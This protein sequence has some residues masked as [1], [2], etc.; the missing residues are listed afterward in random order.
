MVVVIVLMVTRPW[1]RRKMKNKVIATLSGGKDSMF[2]LHK[3]VK[4]GYE[5]AAIVNTISQDFK[6]VRFHGLEAQMIQMQA[7]ALGIPLFQIETTPENYKEEFIANLK[8]AMTPKIGGIVF[9]DIFLEDC[10]IWAKEVSSAVG[11]EAIEPHWGSNS[12]QLLH[13]FVAS[14]IQAVVVSTQANLLGKEWIGRTID[15]SFYEDITKLEGIDPCG[16]NGEY[17]TYVNDSPLFQKRIVL[18]KT[19][20]VERGGYHFLDIQEASLVKKD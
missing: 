9:G 6:R 8:R 7:D 13:N 18:G 1:R 11:V 19:E 14:G 15:Q 2:A 5:V 17:H 10:L 12:Q 20:K 16:E 4:Q 3:A